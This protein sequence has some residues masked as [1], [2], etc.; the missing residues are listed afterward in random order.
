MDAAL[1]VYL[2]HNF[3]PSGGMRSR[4]TT[5]NK[6]KKVQAILTTAQLYYQSIPYLTNTLDSYPKT[7]CPLSLL[8][9]LMQKYECSCH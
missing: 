2:Q 1:A 8:A 7:P 5:V 4:I 3:C 9:C 6:L